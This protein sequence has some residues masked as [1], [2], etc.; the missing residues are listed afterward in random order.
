MGRLWGWLAE[1][2]EEQQQPED[3]T[4]AALLADFLLNFSHFSQSFFSDAVK[5]KAKCMIE[6]N[7]KQ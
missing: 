2:A 1:G 7:K 3:E 6:N 4:V 5:V